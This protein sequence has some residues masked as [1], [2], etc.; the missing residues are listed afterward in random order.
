MNFPHWFMSSSHFQLV[1]KVM[2]SSM[3][4][5]IAKLDR[6]NPYGDPSLDDHNYTQPDHHFAP[7]LVFVCIGNL[8]SGSG[9][10]VSEKSENG[11]AQTDRFSELAKE[12]RMVLWYPMVPLNPLDNHPLFPT[13][14]LPFG[15]YFPR[16]QTHT[17]IDIILL[18]YPIHIPINVYTIDISTN[19]Q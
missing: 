2:R 13:I 4:I 10:G 6:R 18:R 3:A 19:M 17:H 7:C 14:R 8:L 15:A 11:E 16:F 5:A 1:E 12:K 9:L